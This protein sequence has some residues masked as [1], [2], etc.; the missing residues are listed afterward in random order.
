MITITE[1]AD[2]DEKIDK[3][4]VYKPEKGKHF[5]TVNFYKGLINIVYNYDVNT[6]N[7]EKATHYYK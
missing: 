4:K 6:G 3:V 7:Y 2:D 5:K 1:Y